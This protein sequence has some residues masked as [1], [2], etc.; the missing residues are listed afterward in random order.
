MMSANTANRSLDWTLHALAD[1]TRREI[2][3][4]LAQ[5]EARVTDLAAPFQISLNS[6]SKHIRILERAKLVERRAVGRE[7][8]LRFRAEPLYGVQEWISTQQEFWRASLVALDALLS[9]TRV[10]EEKTR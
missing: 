8:F 2:L 10:S 9:Q 6:V 3:R 7:H 4:R 5:A 1:P